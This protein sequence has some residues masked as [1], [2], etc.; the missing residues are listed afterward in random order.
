VN[1]TTPAPAG[2]PPKFRV[3]HPERVIDAQSGLTKGALV[4]YY[5]QVAALMLPHL[6]QR[7]VSLLRA[8]E[9]VGGEQ[10]FQKHAEGRALAN[11]H[12]LDR[13]LDPEHAPL[14]AIT[15]T[16]GLLS[17]AQMN[18]IEFHTWNATTRTIGKPD[19]MVFDLDPGEG[20][21]WPQVR[22]GTQLLKAFLD[23]LGLA[24]FLK[25]SGGKGLHVVVPLTPRFDWGTVKAC[26]QAIV[27]HMAE[28]IPQR[29]VAKSGPKNR[30]GRI[31]IDYLRNGWGA[32]TVAAWSARAR[33]GM[34]I[35][36]PLA[37]DELAGLTSAAQWTV[38]NAGDRLAVGNTPW[39]GYLAA[40]Q[41]LVKPMK[42]LGFDPK[43]GA[44]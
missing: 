43:Q 42:A 37:W 24:S 18:V 8:P 29:F 14:L 26:S 5:A 20:V 35:S 21:S 12:T 34:G 40:K 32:T 2:L 11:V 30:V 44:A 6:R 36:V 22:E 1:T 23:E 3:T 9:G 16:L 27:A 17:A 25:T 41:S 15:S 38:R 28:V 39:E 33:P 7:P 10:F 13:K 31:Y 4:S 19:R